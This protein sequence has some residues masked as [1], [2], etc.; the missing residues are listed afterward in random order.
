L[1]TLVS[2]A[3][4]EPVIWRYTFEK[5]S[6]DWFK[7]SFDDSSWKEGPAGFGTEGTPGSVVRT[8]WNT[9]DIWIRREFDLPD[10]KLNDPRLMIHYDEDPEIYINGI[11]AAQTSG[12]VTGY[13]E[14]DITPEAKRVFKPGKNSIAVHCHQTT[15]GQYIDV[16]I[17]DENAKT[18][19]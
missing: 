1:K 12:Y 18:N 6:D 4:S 11:P 10:M 8:T 14:Y 17:V 13:E 16:G 3:Q 15:G 19:L 2:T 7:P 9:S 5:P